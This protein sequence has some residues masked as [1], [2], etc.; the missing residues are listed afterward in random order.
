MAGAY[1]RRRDTPLMPSVAW[2][3][4]R[5]SGSADPPSQDTEKIFPGQ[6]LADGIPARLRRHL[7]CKLSEGCIY[8]QGHRLLAH[9]RALPYCT[10]SVRHLPYRRPFREC[11]RIDLV[12]TVQAIFNTY[13]K[14]PLIEDQRVRKRTP[15]ALQSVYEQ[16]KASL[17]RLAFN[18]MTLLYD[19]QSRG[20]GRLTS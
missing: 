11:R 15:T 6:V 9:E 7:H 5:T 17:Y 19:E 20:I 12:A 1:Q 4:R 3:A 16:K 18:A 8:L 13:S 14:E 10:R 2:L